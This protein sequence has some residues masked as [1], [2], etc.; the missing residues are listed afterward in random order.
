MTVSTGQTDYL[1]GSIISNLRYIF[2][3]VSDIYL[4]NIQLYSIKIMQICLILTIQ[5]I[6]KSCTYCGT[7]ISLCVQ[8]FIVT[9][10]KYINV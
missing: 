6:S 9:E 5:P 3:V 1:N 8:S 4:Q 7:Y 2:L 10:K